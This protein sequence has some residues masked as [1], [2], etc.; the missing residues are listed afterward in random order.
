MCACSRGEKRGV[1]AKTVGTDPESEGRSEGAGDSGQLFSLLRYLFREGVL[2]RV[3]LP[4]A[5]MTMSEI[6]ERA[7]C[8]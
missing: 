4:M 8:F 2:L 1:E 3:G 6:R 5:G 7:A